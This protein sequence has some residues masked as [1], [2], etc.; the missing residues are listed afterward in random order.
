MGCLASGERFEVGATPTKTWT[1][2][3]P[4]GQELITVI[5]SP[6]PLYAEALPEIQTAE[7]YLPRL[8][9]MLDANR[10]N[11]KLSATY[12]FMQTEPAR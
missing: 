4:L 12:L 10:G 11:A 8:R 2:C 5:A 1:V 3:P 6:T 7:E 9:Q